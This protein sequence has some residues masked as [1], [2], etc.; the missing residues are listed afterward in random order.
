MGAKPLGGKNY[1][2]I[3]QLPGSR[4]AKAAMCRRVA[5]AHLITLQRGYH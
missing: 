5:I 2:N 3:A 4:M 1:G